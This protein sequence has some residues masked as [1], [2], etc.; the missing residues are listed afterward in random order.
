[1]TNGLLSG[2]SVVKRKIFVSYHHGNDRGYYDAFINAFSNA[3]DVVHDNSVERSIN[4][5]NADYVI[6]RIRENYI[7][8]SSCTIVLCGQQT[9]W[10]KFVDWEVKATLDRKHALIGVN[11]PTNPMNSDNKYTVSD[12]LYDNIKSGFAV[13]VDWSAF[14]QSHEA[15]RKYIEEAKSRSI[16]LIDN[17][18]PLRRRNG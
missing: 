4:S 18:R 10:R 6:R 15:V 17:S 3:Y 12:K 2:V 7:T 13:W 11:L 5:D 1:M 16:Q 14:T 9:P 8:G